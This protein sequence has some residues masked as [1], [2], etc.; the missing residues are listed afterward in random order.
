MNRLK[1]KVKSR[2]KHKHIG[3]LFMTEQAL[4]MG[5]E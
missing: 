2:N 3:K 4:Q 5:E 1:R